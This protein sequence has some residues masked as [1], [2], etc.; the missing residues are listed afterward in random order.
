[1][2]V[3]AMSDE[4]EDVIAETAE[5]QTSWDEGEHISVDSGPQEKFDWQS[6]GFDPQ[7][8]VAVMLEV[9]SRRLMPHWWSDAVPA[10]I[11]LTREKMLMI[12]PVHVMLIE[13]Y[14]GFILKNFPLEGMALL[15]WGGLLLPLITS[16]I[17]ARAPTQ[18]AASES[19]RS[20]P[21]GAMSPAYGQSDAAG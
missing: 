19:E 5:Q 15:T 1:M 16:G 17:P 21:V 13:K 3:M 6:L 9:L 4:L 2:R 14:A 8:V 12:A 10:D 20:A 18:P 7:P 11:R